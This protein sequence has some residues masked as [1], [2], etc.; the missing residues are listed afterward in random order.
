MAIRGIEGLSPEQINFELQRGG[1]FVAGRYPPTRL[2]GV[3]GPRRRKPR[4]ARSPVDTA[5]LP[6]GMV[7]DSV[8]SDLYHPVAGDRFRRRKRR[9]CPGAIAG[10][11]VGRGGGRQSLG[12]LHYGSGWR[13]G[14]HFNFGPRLQN[15]TG[16]VPVLSSQRQEDKHWG[17][18]GSA[19]R[20]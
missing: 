11:A 18:K 14:F 2:A 17:G 15:W 7:G 8:G 10:T 16:R 1:K 6:A 12:P 13:A 4:W 9:N 3:L 5:Y 19:R 20:C